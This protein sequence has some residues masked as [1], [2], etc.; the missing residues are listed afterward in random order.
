MSN[1]HTSFTK[2]IEIEKRGKLTPTKKKG[3]LALLNKKGKLLGEYHQISVFIESDNKIT[4]NIENTKAS[5]AIVIRRNLINNRVKCVLKVKVGKMES[6]TRDEI[7]IPFTYNDLG[8]ILDLLRVFGISKGCPRF[9]HRLDYKLGNYLISIK[10]KGLLYDH[11][12]I[13]TTVSDSSQIEN[14]EKKMKKWLRDVKLSAFSE[15]KYKHLLIKIFKENPP[16]DF[17]DID[18]NVAKKVK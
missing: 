3:L 6:G 18:F 14:M 4:G 16:I 15:E 8:H 5:I 2:T 13:E 11:F 17:A 9:Y 10:D 12:E 1:S 7:K